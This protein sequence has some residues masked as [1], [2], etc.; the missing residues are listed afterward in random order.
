M[1]NLGGKERT[2]ANFVNVLEKAGWKLV[3]IH[4]ISGMEQCHIVGVPA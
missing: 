2:I 3:R 4:R 1:H